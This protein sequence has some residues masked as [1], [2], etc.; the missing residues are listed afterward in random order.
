MNQSDSATTSNEP[1]QLRRKALNI[2]ALAEHLEK[3]PPIDEAAVDDLANVIRDTNLGHRLTMG[4]V[5]ALVR[6]GVR[7]DGAK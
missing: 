5:R 4:D 3:H 7:V 6:A 2:L 1:D